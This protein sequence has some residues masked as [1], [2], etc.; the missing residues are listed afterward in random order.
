[1]KY[2][3]ELKQMEIIIFLTLL[4]IDCTATLMH[5]SSVSSKLHA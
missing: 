5:N 4:Q 1:L 3:R 2:G